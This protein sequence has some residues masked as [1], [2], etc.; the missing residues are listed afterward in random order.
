MKT[1]RFYKILI[2][3]LLVINLVTIFF[4]WKSTGNNHLPHGPRKSLVEILDLKGDA[5]KK[6]K[7]LE[8][9]HFRLKDSLMDQ[10][11]RLHERLFQSSKNPESDQNEIDKSIDKIV[12]NQRETVLMTYQYFKKVSLICTPEQQEKLQKVLHHALRMN[13]PPPPPKR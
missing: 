3:I 10:S 12:E 13:G 7:T 4:L 2:G 8:L 9:E 6:I 1:T 5:A 11:R